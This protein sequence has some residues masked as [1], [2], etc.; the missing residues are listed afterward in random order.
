MAVPFYRYGYRQAKSDMAVEEYWASEAENERCC[1]YI[2]SPETGLIAK[3]YKNYIVET[4]GK[5][6]DEIIKEFGLERVMF[7]VASTVKAS[8]N[9]GRWTK[10]VKDWGMRFNAGYKFGDEA[11]QYTLQQLNPGI[12][13]L[14]AKG[15]IKK[16]NDLNLFEYQHCKTSCED[17]KGKIFVLSHTAMKE[18]YWSPEYQLW[19]AKGGFG[20]QANAIGRAVYAT[21]LYDGE[22]TRWSRE[23]IVGVIKEEFMPDWAKEKLNEILYQTNEM[24]LNLN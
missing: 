11:C 9:D 22:E 14:I 10:E 17:M 12:V 1:E 24:N 19:L 18:E 4:D 20:C 3:A 13:D 2:Q 16:Y 23:Q 21:C 7:V 5:Y 6:T 8:P 15:L